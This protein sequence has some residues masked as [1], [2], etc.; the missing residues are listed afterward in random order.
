MS[1]LLLKETTGT[2]DGVQTNGRQVSTDC[3]SDLENLESFV[4]T[5][6]QQNITIIFPDINT[7]TESHRIFVFL[8]LHK[9]FSYMFLSLRS[10]CASWSRVYFQDIC[11]FFLGSKITERNAAS[12][13]FSHW[14]VSWVNILRG[15]CKTVLPPSLSNSI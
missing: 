8:I 3:E 9:S 1:I 7:W 5:C 11:L 2:F 13:S 15:E 14:K 10:V 12:N 6:W 4:L